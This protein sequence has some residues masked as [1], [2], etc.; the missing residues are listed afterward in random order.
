MG[1]SGSP[2]GVGV[3][4]VHVCLPSSRDGFIQPGRKPRV[5]EWN[6]G[7]GGGGGGVWG[8]LVIYFSQQTSTSQPRSWKLT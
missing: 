1:C 7:G 3:V 6:D 8:F 2:V 4:A 5:G